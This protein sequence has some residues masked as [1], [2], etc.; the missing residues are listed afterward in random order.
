MHLR[1]VTPD[2]FRKQDDPSRDDG[3]SGSLSDDYRADTWLGRIGVV[4]ARFPRF[5]GGEHRQSDFDVYVSWEDVEKILEKF[6]EAKHAEA[7][8]LQEARKLAEAIKDAGWRKQ[9]RFRM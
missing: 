6:C 3:F 4:I 1:C 7:I 2:P 9:Q 5:G 8:A